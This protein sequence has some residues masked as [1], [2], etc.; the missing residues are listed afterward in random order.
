VVAAAAGA[1]N[2]ELRAIM[3]QAAQELGQWVTKSEPSNLNVNEM[4][5]G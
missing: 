3:R 4:P 1:P 5:S 2:A